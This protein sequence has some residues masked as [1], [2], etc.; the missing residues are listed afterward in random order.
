ML[1]VHLGPIQ[2]SVSASLAS[3]ILGMHGLSL[4]NI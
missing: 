3:Y 1:I 2:A 4:M